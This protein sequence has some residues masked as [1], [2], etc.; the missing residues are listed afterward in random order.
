MWRR[1]PSSDRI[2][3]ASTRNLEH[4]G[5]FSSSVPAE[6]TVPYFPFSFL[7]PR[8]VCGRVLSYCL[9]LF[10]W[11]QVTLQH[12]VMLSS[13][14]NGVVSTSARPAHKAKKG[15][16]QTFFSS[17]TRL[18]LAVEVIQTP[19]PNPHDPITLF[20]EQYAFNPYEDTRIHPFSHPAEMQIFLASDNWLD[21]VQD[22]D[23][24]Q[25]FKTLEVHCKI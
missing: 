9:R 25:M 16:A 20:E 2:A 7:C 23:K 21:E 15:P 13:L 19:T 3:L 11:C 18:Y 5:W 17:L 6:V 24:A 12:V 14:E 4:M 1:E 10:M 8:R 22:M